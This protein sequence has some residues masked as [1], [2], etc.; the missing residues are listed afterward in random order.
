M[1]K[2][3]TK[4]VN[5]YLYNGKALNMST[6]K[7]E[8]V[9]IV[10]D[11]NYDVTLS[12]SAKSLQGL[13]KAE[14]GE[15]YKLYKLTSKDTA[16][17]LYRMTEDL[18]KSF[19]VIVDKRKQGNYIARS[20]PL[21]SALVIGVLNDEEYKEVT[22]KSCPFGDDDS[23]KEYSIMLAGEGFV[24]VDVIDK[25]VNEEGLLYQMSDADFVRYAE[26]VESESK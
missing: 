6:K 12:A 17:G 8:D 22:I 26:K 11:R 20:F 13:L 9:Q 19:A 25:A 5:T 4:T 24:P 21:Y 7:I 1:A 15:S 2:Y 10:S 14:K 3:V 16:C 18:F 23:I